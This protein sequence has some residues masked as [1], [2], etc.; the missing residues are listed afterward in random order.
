MVGS[1]GADASVVA[2]WVGWIKT[3]SS[4]LVVSLGGIVSS[5]G[6]MGSDGLWRL[7]MEWEA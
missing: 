3:L 6:A 1:Y 5:A 4:V 2:S 7:E